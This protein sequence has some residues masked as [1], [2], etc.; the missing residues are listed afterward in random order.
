MSSISFSGMATLKDLSPLGSPAGNFEN[1]SVLMFLLM[2][3]K[4]LFVVFLLMNWKIVF[5]DIYS[6][7]LEILFVGI[8]CDLKMGYPSRNSYSVDADIY[9]IM[10]LVPVST[11]GRM[12]TDSKR[13]ELQPVA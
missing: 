1:L 6:N 4:I 9:F 10:Y 13:K 12:H 5:V 11:Q 7:D 3:W 8:R 2:I